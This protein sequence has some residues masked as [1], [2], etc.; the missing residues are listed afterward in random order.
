MFPPPSL[1][2]YYTSSQQ[3]ENSSLLEISLYNL[4]TLIISLK[5]DAVNAKAKV[6]PA[7]PLEFSQFILN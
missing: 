7:M 5:K 1:L 4:N 3:L 2:L 6:S